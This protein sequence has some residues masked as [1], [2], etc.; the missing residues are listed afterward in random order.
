MPRTWACGTRRSGDWPQILIVPLLAY[1]RDGYRLGWGA[2]YYDRTLEQL[3]ASSKVVAIGVGFE[4]QHV[5]KVPRD[6]HDQRL[7]FMVTEK[8]VVEYRE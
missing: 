1:D 4:L 5:D 3:R 6:R 2:G 7:D 8:G